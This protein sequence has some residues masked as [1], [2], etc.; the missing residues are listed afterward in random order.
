MI[1]THTHAALSF[2]ISI[3]FHYFYYCTEVAS[4]F[5]YAL[6]LVPAQPQKDLACEA[7][8]AESLP[9]PQQQLLSCGHPTPAETAREGKPARPRTEGSK[10]FKKRRRNEIREQK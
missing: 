5:L 4:F 1:K 3:H 10:D 9:P 8:Q 6:P 7:A 2:I